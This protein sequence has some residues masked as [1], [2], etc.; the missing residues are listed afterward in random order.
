MTLRK[1]IYFVPRPYPY[2]HRCTPCPRS[3]H[4]DHIVERRV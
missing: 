1:L 2:P 3:E 4:S